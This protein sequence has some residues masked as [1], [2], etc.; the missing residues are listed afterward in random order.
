MSRGLK[1]ELSAYGEDN[2]KLV[3]PDYSLS[4]D[5]IHILSARNV[6]GKHQVNNG[7]LQLVNDN[8]IN[9]TRN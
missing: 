1:C 2:I 4:V 8:K 6:S 7:K 3:L 9:K 5:T